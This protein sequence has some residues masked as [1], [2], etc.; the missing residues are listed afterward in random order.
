MGKINM[1]RDW[2]DYFQEC[3]LF[4]GKEYVNSVDQLKVSKD[5]ITAVV[6]GG[7]YYTMC[8]AHSMALMATSLA[9]RAGIMSVDI[10]P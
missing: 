7:E 1:K 9:L 8:S 3:I 2:E 5:K 10:I 6:R 4:R